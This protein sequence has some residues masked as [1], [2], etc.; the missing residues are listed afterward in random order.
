[1]VVKY[2]WEASKVYRGISSHYVNYI[3]VGRIDMQ[4]KYFAKNDNSATTLQLPHCMNYITVGRKE[5]QIKYF[6]ILL[7]ICIYGLAGNLAED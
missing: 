1:M 6:T 3:S 5:T 2:L 4:I 7:L